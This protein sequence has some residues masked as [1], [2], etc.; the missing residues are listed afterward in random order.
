MKGN[1]FKFKSNFYTVMRDM[2]DKQAGEFIKGVC[3]Y[4]FDGK[5]L[6]TKDEYLKGVYLYVKRELDVSAMNAINGKKGA[7]KLA[8]IK[9]KQKVAKNLGVLIETVVVTSKTEKN[10]KSNK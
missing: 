1:S 4:V 7:D 8:E 10:G 9:Q 3:G 2:T 6:A 5:P